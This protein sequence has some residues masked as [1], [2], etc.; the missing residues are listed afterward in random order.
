MQNF[1]L[2]GLNLKPDEMKQAEHIWKMLDDMAEN[3]PES[4]KQFIQK[5]VS[6]GVQNAKTEREKEI[7][8]M[9]AKPKIGYLLKMDAQIT[10]VTP[11]KDTTEEY[12]KFIV[13]KPEENKKEDHPENAKIYLNIC[14]SD[15]VLK[16]LTK[17]GVVSSNIQDQQSWHN[18][19]VSFPD[20]VRSKHQYEDLV[21]IYFIAIINSELY[22]FI[23]T[24]K[25]VLQSVQEY[26]LEKL[27]FRLKTDRNPI[28][29]YNNAEYK[30]YKID[31]KTVILRQKKKFKVKGI[32]EPKEYLLDLDTDIDFF[33]KRQKA[34]EKKKEVLLKKEETTV[35]PDIKIGTTVE[36]PSTS[37]K[38]PLIQEIGE[39]LNEPTYNL[40]DEPGKYIVEIRLDEEDLLGGF[41]LDASENTIKL[42]IPSKKL[43]V[44][45]L[46]QNI[47][48]DEVKA[49]L[50]KKKKLLIIEA[51]KL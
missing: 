18:I 50:K 19:P 4:Y 43:L 16:P 6:E 21:S 20:F 39:S 5:S 36:P 44:I 2:G 32:A 13:K 9:G 41:D 8:E 24:N 22:S 47:L 12:S 49:V 27:Q 1:N 45:N 48:R 35:A 23:Q 33:N 40:S 31:P 28:P 14:H 3:N 30:Y 25:A 7:K 26:I 37:S 38:K 17:T 29:N 51:N 10:K 34:M 46:K 11:E 42:Q 15:K